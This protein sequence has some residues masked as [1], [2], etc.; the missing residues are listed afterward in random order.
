MPSEVF[1]LIAG[2]FGSGK[3]TLARGIIRSDGGGKNFKNYLVTNGGKY[4]FFGR[5]LESSKY[6]GADG[7]SGRTSATL[8]SVFLQSSTPFFIAE[9]KRLFSFG[10]LFL[11]TFYIAKRQAIISLDCDVETTLKRIEERS[12]RTGENSNRTYLKTYNSILEKYISIG[13]PVFRINANQTKEVV[14]KETLDIIRGFRDGV[15]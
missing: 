7:V 8:N 15:L 2:L 1:I 9:G 11:Q 3:S 5:Y 4:T 6:G 13:T 10:A 14:L 12:G